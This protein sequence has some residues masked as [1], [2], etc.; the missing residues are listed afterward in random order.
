MGSRARDLHLGSI[1]R[2]NR[3]PSDFALCPENDA[4]PMAYPRRVAPGQGALG[5]PFSRDNSP[6]NDRNRHRKP[7]QRYRLAG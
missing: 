4:K 6:A 5:R 2:K 1:G 3:P 7:G